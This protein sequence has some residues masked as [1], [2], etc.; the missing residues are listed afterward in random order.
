[1]IRKDGSYWIGLGLIIG[2]LP[3]FVLIVDVLA[4]A[5]Y[6]LIFE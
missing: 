3:W 2:L 4:I 5:L 6:S 1:L